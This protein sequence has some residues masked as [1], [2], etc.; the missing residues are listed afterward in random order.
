MK[1]TENLKLIYGKVKRNI[2]S[3]TRIV[4]SHNE[5]DLMTQMGKWGNEQLL[6]SGY[7]TIRFNLLLFIRRYLKFSIS[8]ILFY[9][10]K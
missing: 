1:L 3:Y 9:N 4:S 10:M 7:V 5:H 8:N 6:R 2:F